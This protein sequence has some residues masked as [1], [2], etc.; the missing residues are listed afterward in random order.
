MGAGQLVYVELYTGLTVR[1]GERVMETKGG[2]EGSSC[3][4]LEDM[5]PKYDRQMV[6]QG[7]NEED[8]LLFYMVVTYQTSSSQ[9]YLIS[10]SSGGRS[11]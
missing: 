5:S 8:L 11:S 10:S 7:A 1:K 6:G 4:T 9:P 3:R 2:G